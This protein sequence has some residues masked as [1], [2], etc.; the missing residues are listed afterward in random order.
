M[1]IYDSCTAQLS[2]DVSEFK[3]GFPRNALSGVTKD[4]NLGL[5]GR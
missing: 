2:T 3:L 1:L 5:A 4:F